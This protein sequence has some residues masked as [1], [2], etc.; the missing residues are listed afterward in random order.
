M[1]I[2]SALRADHLCLALCLTLLLPLAACRS[3]PADEVIREIQAGGGP[4]DPSVRPVDWYRGPGV[5]RADTGPARFTSEVRTRFDM[6]LAQGLLEFAD[7]YYRA[8]ANEGYEAVLE[9]LHAELAA[10]GFGVGEGLELEWFE[11]PAK[12]PAWTP[13]SASVAVRTEFGEGSGWQTLH[14]FDAP[15]DPDRVVLPINAMACDIE[16]GIALSLDELDEGEVFVT[17]VSLAQV[18]HRAK[19]R[20]AAAVVSSSL[21]SFNEDTS[22]AERHLD[23]IQ[24]VT[25]HADDELPVFQISPRSHTRIAELVRNADDGVVPLIRLTAVVDTEER[26]LR[27]LVAT[28]VGDSLP[29]EAVVVVSHVQ[30]PGAND[31]ASGLAGLAAGAVGLVRALDEGTLARPARSLAFVWG[32]EFRQSEAWLEF[33]GRTAVAGLS[34]D[35]IGESREKTG[36]IALLERM[37]DPG[38]LRPLP[39]DE[40]TPWGAGDVDAEEF[41]PNGLAVVARC[42]MVDVGLLEGGWAAADHPWEGGS[43]HDVFIRAGVPGVLFW[44]FTDFAYHTSLDRLEMV[45]VKEVRR[46]STAILAT[47]LAVADPQPDDLRRYIDSVNAERILRVEVALGAEDEELAEAWR[48]WTTGARNWLRMLCW[49]LDDEADEPPADAPAAE[50]G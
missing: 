48:V 45:D 11:M 20:G 47:A 16:A 21:E 5:R 27:T 32:D 28:I 10:A 49:G 14:R 34:S 40:H 26:P 36:A 35:M 17:E 12:L 19:A 46:M 4:A 42:A 7:G 18:L 33:S 37:P 38:A 1:R 24:F 22:G 29:D 13:R 39:P 3:D 44:H 23:A 2:P 31:N 15:G 41:A 43:D 25:A 50:R 9:R 30:E 6:R 8:P